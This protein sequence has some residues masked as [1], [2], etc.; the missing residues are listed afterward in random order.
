MSPGRL[1]CSDLAKTTHRM[2]ADRKTLREINEDTGKDI[3]WISEILSG[4]GS[5]TGQKKDA[6]KRGRRRNETLDNG[7]LIKVSVEDDVAGTA[8]SDQPV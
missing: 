7:E 5:V 3:N 1:L 2:R 6:R 4:Y 8:W